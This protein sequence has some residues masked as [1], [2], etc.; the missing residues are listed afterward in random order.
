[1]LREGAVV[2]TSATKDQSV[3]S[4]AQAMIGEGVAASSEPRPAS[5]SMAAR[6][7][8]RGDAL[9]LSRESGYG[10]AIRHATLSV[11][12]GEVVGIAAI[13]GNG[14]RELL[15]AIAGRIVPL[16]GKLQVAQPVGF[17]PE[18]RTSEGLISS[19]SLT[20][21]VVLGLGEDAPWISS[22]RVDWKQ[23]ERTT[24]ELLRDLEVVS[25]GPRTRA[26]ALS[27][28]NQQKLV[29]AREL[30]RS[31]AVVV[32]EN[33][34]RGLDIRATR[35]VHARLRSA[36]AAGASVLFHSADLDEV[37]ELA[38]RIIVVTRGVI[39]EAPPNATRA[40]IGTMMLHPGSEA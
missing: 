14:Q 19:F 22:G 34:T 16:R 3:D 31:P 25:T 30:F 32:A 38:Q 1:V 21:N 24:A 37:L 11:R 39:R 20:E 29:V 7:T 8:I 2:A 23:A 26:G 10:I 17:I 36:A 27:G 6:E 15:R 40:E 33:P 12:A 5:V 18:D 9:E 4:L 35:D 13:E 28:G